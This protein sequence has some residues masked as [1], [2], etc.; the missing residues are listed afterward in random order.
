MNSGTVE[1]LLGF[2]PRWL[3]GLVALGIVFS[4]ASAM[5]LLEGFL[6]W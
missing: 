2:V 5:V 3:V 6:P 1:V 4:L